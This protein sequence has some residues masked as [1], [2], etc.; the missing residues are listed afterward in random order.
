MGRKQKKAVTVY[1]NFFW[2]NEGL[3]PVNSGGGDAKYTFVLCRGNY[4]GVV[5][6]ALARRPW[7]RDAVLDQ[8]GHNAHQATTTAS[9]RKLLNERQD[10]IAMQE[11][12]QQ[13][14]DFAAGEPLT[15]DIFGRQY[16]WNLF[17]HNSPIYA[18]RRPPP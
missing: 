10:A 6:S 17:S 1:H 12:E 18:V 9:Q 15:Q 11:L 3:M 5:R 7:W 2:E 4:S 14:K 8:C 13:A 16:L